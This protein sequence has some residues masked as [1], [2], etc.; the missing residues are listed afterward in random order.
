MLIAAARGPLIRRKVAVAAPSPLVIHPTTPFVINVAD[1]STASR[2]FTISGAAGDLWIAFA[3]LVHAT[4][5]INDPAGW[6]SPV[7]ADDH[8][9]SAS[10]KM[11]V[12]SRRLTG[13]TTNPE[14]TITQSTDEW[15]CGLVAVQG[16]AAVGYIHKSAFTKNAS[17]TSP[18]CPA[19]VTEVDNCLILRG[20]FGRGVVTA[21]DANWPSGTNL[22][23]V[24]DA[25]PMENRSCFGVAW[26]V[27][28]TAG[29][30]VTA[31]F[32]GVKANNTEFTFTIA[33]AP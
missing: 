28:E 17:S 23:F 25:V 11:S 6:D 12:W 21:E 31:T 15:S 1:T 13:P 8:D 2:T 32:S 27:Q 24:R 4:A 30:T 14:I 18:V 5:T 20:F 29:D 19:V 7:F 10:F 33:V 16:A 22:L 3:G 26:E 9:N